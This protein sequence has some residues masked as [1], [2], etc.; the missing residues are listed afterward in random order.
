MMRSEAL[1]RHSQDTN[2]NRPHRIT[3]SVCAAAVT[4]AFAF[5]KQRLWHWHTFFSIFFS[6]DFGWFQL[7]EAF[8][9]S[10]LSSYLFLALSE[11][12]SVSVV[13]LCVDVSDSDGMW[14]VGILLFGTKFFRYL[15]FLLAQPHE[16]RSQP[17]IQREKKENENLTE[18]LPFDFVWIRIGKSILSFTLHTCNARVCVPI[19]IYSAAQL[20]ARLHCFTEQLTIPSLSLSLLLAQNYDNVTER[21]P[22]YVSVVPYK[23]F[24][25]LRK[26]TEKNTHKIQM[27]RFKI[28]QCVR[29]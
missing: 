10:S 16:Y 8:F 29:T 9:L 7:C 14:E 20:N 1:T 24:T 26:I 6:D 19:C 5:A 2:T 22:L 28:K 12:H 17:E 13:R 4:V 11:K 21:L 25:F 27:A 18:H 3:Y 23:S 15:W